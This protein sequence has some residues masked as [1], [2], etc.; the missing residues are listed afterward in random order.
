MFELVESQ[1]DNIASHESHDDCNKQCSETERSESERVITSVAVKSVKSSAA[2]AHD[3]LE[4]MG[5]LKCEVGS[6][7]T[8][9]THLKDAVEYLRGELAELQ[10][11]KLSNT[12]ALQPGEAITSMCDYDDDSL[13]K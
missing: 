7:K 8:D 9:F 5:N 13:L 11:S 10:K 3:P 4:S 1:V 6:L 12:I 2:S